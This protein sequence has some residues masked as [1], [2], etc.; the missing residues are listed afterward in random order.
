MS[1]LVLTSCTSLKAAPAESLTRTAET[2]YTGQQHVRLMRGV[3]AYR[4]AGEPQGKLDLRIVSAGHG[5]LTGDAEIERYDETFS[6]AP[7]S[8]VRRRGEALGVPRAVAD[9]LE[10]DWDLALVLLGDLYL[11]AA[12]LPQGLRLGGPT[13]ALASPRAASRIP[14]VPNMTVVELYNAEAR[15]FSCGLTSL[16]GELAGRLLG[17]LANDSIHRVPREPPVFLKSLETLPERDAVQLQMV[18]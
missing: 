14:L 2:L 1:I 10:C 9:L 13:I 8:E 7:R 12:A 4:R 17:R 11:H 6:G 16:K 15:R 3:T 5:V 18:G